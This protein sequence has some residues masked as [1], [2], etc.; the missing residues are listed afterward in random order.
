MDS[1][2]IKEGVRLILEGIGEDVDREGLLVIKGSVMDL[3]T[4]EMLQ[5]ILSGMEERLNTKIE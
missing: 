3:E 5:A 2:K 1:E 4:K